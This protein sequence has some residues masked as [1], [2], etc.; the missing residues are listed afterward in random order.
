MSTAFRV[1]ILAIFRSNFM[2]GLLLCLT[3][4][5]Q[6]P[7]TADAK[8]KDAV[9][10]AEAARKAYYESLEKLEEALVAD[11]KKQ[12]DATTKAGNLDGALAIRKE[13]DKIE[14]GDFVSIMEDVLGHSR[15][16]AAVEN[17]LLGRWRVELVKGGR[18]TFS[19]EWT[20]AKDGTITSTNPTG[21]PKGTW[22]TELA[23]SRVYIDWGSGA[24]ET[25]TL[26]LRPELAVGESWSG[27]DVTMRAKKLESPK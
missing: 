20:F 8:I 4:C 21:A 3:L 10:K 16:L 18:T 14:T 22:K 9:N 19:S 24:W 25:F 1:L 13:I 11:L 17:S 27:M 12:L 6:L 2:H 23:K 15:L 7:P 5:G 26:P